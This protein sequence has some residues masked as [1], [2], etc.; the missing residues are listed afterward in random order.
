MN[1][2]MVEQ[3]ATNGKAKIYHWHLPC[4]C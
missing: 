1:H 4:F 2:Q 3:F